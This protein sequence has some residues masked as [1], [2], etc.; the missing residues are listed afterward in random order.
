VVRAALAVALVLALAGCSGDDDGDG[1]GAGELERMVVLRDD[2]EGSGWTRFDWGRQERSDQPT[3]QR[4]DPARFGRVDGWK[5]RYRRP[6]SP[7]TSGPLVVESRADVF[8][9]SDG[10]RSD[11]DAYGSELETSGTPL[12]EVPD[13]GE[14]AIVA[15]LRQGDVRFF[16]VMWRDANAVAA[17]NANGFDRKLTREQALEL[18]RKQQARMRSAG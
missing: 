16:L 11:F 1:Y 6:G 13:L 2:L 3:G 15:T 12:E 17:I 4:S 14:R 8:E 9:A 7:Q 18:A 10:A 5:A